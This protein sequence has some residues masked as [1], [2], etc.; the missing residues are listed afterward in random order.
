MAFDLIVKNARLPDGR[1]AMDVACERGRIAAVEPGITAEAGRV[2]DAAARL[3][4]PPFVD[5]HFHMDSTLTL[6]MPR[7]NRSG[8]LLEGIALWG[9][10]KPLLA[11]EAVVER[12]MRYCD[13]AVS[14]GLLVIRSHVDIC[15][16]RLVGLEALI[17]VKRKAK[18]YLDLQLVA[19]PQDGY[20]RSPAA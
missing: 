11:V 16:D 13:L 10:L 7:L 2:I 20:L 1:Q 14:Q 19:F 9:E 5:P 15:D 4:T 12:A 8:T 3:V 6:G 17:A 18:P